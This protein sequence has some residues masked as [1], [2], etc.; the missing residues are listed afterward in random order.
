MDYCNNRLSTREDI[1]RSLAND[2]V[3]GPNTPHESSH[4]LGSNDLYDKFFSLE[5]LLK[6]ELQHHL[7]AIFLRMYIEENIVPKGLL[8]KVEPAFKNDPLFVN[9]WNNHLH[10]CSR[11]LVLKLIKK[12]ES[13]CTDLNAQ[14]SPLV[15]ELAVNKNHPA[16]SKCDRLLTSRILHM[17]REML[18]KKSKKIRRDRSDNTPKIIPRLMELQCTTP[19]A[20]KFRTGMH[21]SKN[22]HISKPRANTP[23]NCKDNLP[24]PMATTSAVPEHSV[25]KSRVNTVVKT[26]RRLNKPEAPKNQ[27]NQISNLEHLTIPPIPPQNS[28][29]EQNTLAMIELNIQVQNQASD[30]STVPIGPANTSENGDTNKLNTTAPSDFPDNAKQMTSLCLPPTSFNAI[31]SPP[32]LESCEDSISLD[33]SLIT[34]YN[35]PRESQLYS[36]SP[37]KCDNEQSSANNKSIELSFLGLPQKLTPRGTYHIRQNPHSTKITNFFHLTGQKRKHTEENEEENPPPLTPI[38]LSPKF[39]PAT[40]ILR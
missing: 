39:P 6:S 12:R 33:D 14:I 4:L 13:L 9:D 35:T 1:A 24:E 8:L 32:L 3:P 40:K 36:N 16:F 26:L 23:I 5:K 15:A 7:D 25:L 30:T 21:T 10:E 29:V 18:D 27:P 37:K 19:P 20:K 38:N 34:I 22:I 2:R 31:Q 11:G 28:L 17:E